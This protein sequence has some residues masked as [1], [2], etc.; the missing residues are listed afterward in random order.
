MNFDKFEDCLV[1]YTKSGWV[2]QV[3]LAKW[4]KWVFPLNKGFLIWDQAPQHWYFYQN[5]FHFKP[6]Y[7][8]LI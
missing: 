2:S 3:L 6:W 7:Q 4:T 1:G 8:I 5:V